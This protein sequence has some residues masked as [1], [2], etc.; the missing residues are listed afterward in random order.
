MLL[1][2]QPAFVLSNYMPHIISSLLVLLFD[3]YPVTNRGIQEGL[4][5]LASYRNNQESS[6]R[7]LKDVIS[8]FLSVVIILEIDGLSVKSIL[9]SSLTKELESQVLVFG[10]I[11]IMMSTKVCCFLH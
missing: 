9:Q 10:L 3:N 2:R 5:Q 11:P 4:H 1:V 8:N 7:D 6:P